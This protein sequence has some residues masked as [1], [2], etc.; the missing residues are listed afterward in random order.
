VKFPLG[1]WLSLV[2]NCA[3]I[4]LQAQ[5]VAALRFMKMAPG[6]APA[7]AEAMRMIT[8]KMSAATDAAMILASG[9]ST[10]QIVARTRRRVRANAR[11]LSRRRKKK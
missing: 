3:E 11:R 1:S 8:E 2:R 10:R 9:G 7:N 6:G 5:Q 4:S